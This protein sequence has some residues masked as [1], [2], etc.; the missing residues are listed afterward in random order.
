VLKD[1]QSSDAGFVSQAQLLGLFDNRALI[2]P[3]LWTPVCF[4]SSLLP[5]P[6]LLR[7]RIEQ[8]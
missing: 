1:D 8:G 7:Y 3:D 5:V 6:G 2:S 4:G